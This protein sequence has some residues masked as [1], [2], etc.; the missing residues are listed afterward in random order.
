MKCRTCNSRRFRKSLLKREVD[1]L[2]FGKTCLKCEAMTVSKVKLEDIK[3]SLIDKYYEFDGIEKNRDIFFILSF[4]FLY[5][6]LYR[7][8][9]SRIMPSIIKGLQSMP[10]KER[11]VLM[12]DKDI[13]RFFET[14][15]DNNNRP[16]ID[17]LI[18]MWAEKSRELGLKA[19][20]DKIS[21]E[22]FEMVVYYFGLDSL[23][24]GKDIK[25]T[26][27]VRYSRLSMNKARYEKWIK[28]ISHRH[29]GMIRD[30]KDLPCM[31]GY[32]DLVSFT[33]AL[34]N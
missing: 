30:I 27:K 9:Y 7:K 28:H 8:L 25:D 12:S 15:P 33:Q 2:T 29:S 24:E 3:N 22:A 17:E 21:W 26:A 14:V 23:F 18:A 10:K 11:S 31:F 4:G 5:G 13:K 1:S 6:F 16:I 32:K 19:D 34:F 20:S